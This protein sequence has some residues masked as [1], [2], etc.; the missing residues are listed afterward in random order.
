MK[1]ICERYWI[2]I[3]AETEQDQAY[4]R[5]LFGFPDPHPVNSYVKP[6]STGDAVYALR[7]GAKE[8]P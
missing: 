2:E 8:R 4:L 1:M 5:A 3:V 6:V 7:L